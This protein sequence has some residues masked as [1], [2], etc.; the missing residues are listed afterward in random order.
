MALLA[1]DGIM[2]HRTRSAVTALVV[3]LAVAAVIATTGRTDATRRSVLA[4]L[5]D[6]SA[7][8]IRVVDRTGQAGLSPQ[9]ATRI[10]GLR[11]V[12]WVVALSPAGALAHNPSI[13]GPLQGFGRDVVGTR[14]YWGRL[15]DSPLVDQIAG[16]PPRVGEAVAGERA[17]GDLGLA[18]RVGAIMDERRGPVAV[19][20]TVAVAPAVEGLGNYV[21]IR[22]AAAE[23]PVGEILIL[24]RASVD[25]EPLVDRLPDLL[26]AED[27]RSIGIDRAEELLSLRSALAQEVGELD[28]AV[29]VGSLTSSALL[30]AA[31][32]Y[33]AVTERRREFG[34][35]RSQG[36]T[37]SNI[38]TLVVVEAWMLAGAGA[39]TGAVLGAVVMA[40]QTG[41]FPDPMLS[42][43][44]VVLVTLAALA[45]SLPAAASAALGEPLYVLR[46]A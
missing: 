25:V 20:A 43:S 10:A 3:G 19:V 18:D 37:R 45:G 39:V 22:G 13:G 17:A 15:D 29:L 9:V 23:G 30:I 41:T 7:R 44:I 12:A 27:V 21:L 8:L 40:V 11:S 34:L 5:E 16:R 46:S 32:L 28:A 24:A 33:G 31:I 38:G 1:R 35:R 42:G 36:A 4:R 26:A 6:P 2:R 14:L